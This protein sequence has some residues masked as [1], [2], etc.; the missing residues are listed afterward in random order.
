MAQARAENRTHLRP[1]SVTRD[2]KL[3]GKE[4]QTTKAEIIADVSFV[5]PDVKHYAIRQ[6]NGM[7]L[8][9]KIVRQMLEH[10]TDIVKD[11]GSTDL[12]P[13]NYDFR[14]VREEAIERPAL[15]RVGDGS[16]AQRQDPA[17]RSNLGGRDHLP[18]SPHRR[19][20]PGRPPPGGCGTRAS[21]WSTVMSAACGCRRLRSPLPMSGSWARI[22][23]LRA[24]WNIS[25]ANLR[26]A[27][28]G[29]AGRIEMPFRWVARSFCLRLLSSSV[30]FGYS[31]L[32][33]EAIVDSL[34][35]ASIQKLLL[36]RFPAATPE[37]LE[38]AHAYAYGGCI[39][40]DMGYYPFSSRFSA[41]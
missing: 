29:P 25:S 10:E 7:G 20:N 37:E 33:H 19:A 3:F 27:H 39:I 23:W 6:A 4:K 21:C 24:M 18:A 12:T 2:Y 11:Y 14:F 36:K 1:Y 34:W 17:P 28:R 31:V 30:S 16:E 26:R 35:D 13:A 38:K 5:P 9:E 41:I 40:Q 32:T 15:L 22:R 8:G